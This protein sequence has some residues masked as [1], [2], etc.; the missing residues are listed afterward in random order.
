MT[1]SGTRT[2]A[3]LSGSLLACAILLSI[4]PALGQ[5]DWCAEY[6][7]DREGYEEDLRYARRTGNSEMVDF[8]E[9]M[10]KKTEIEIRRHCKQ[11]ERV[12]SRIKYGDTVP[13]SDSIPE[14]E[15]AYDVKIGNWSLKGRETKGLHIIHFASALSD[16]TLIGVPRYYGT[17]LAFHCVSDSPGPPPPGFRK[18]TE[19]SEWG[20]FHFQLP[21][22]VQ[23]LNEGA[24]VRVKVRADGTDDVLDIPT[25]I[26]V[27][28]ANLDFQ[29]ESMRE[30]FLSMVSTSERMYVTF[31]AAD[32]PLHSQIDL[33]G[34][35]EVVRTLRA[36]CGL[37]P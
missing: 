12:D 24:R 21:E 5:T 1:I 4:Q 6:K 36:F 15:D 22:A 32:G 19:T 2:N 14:S 11:T 25:T 16:L 10:L 27:A 31:P 33:A 35:A 20:S 9:H 23:G 37:E 13:R 34:G 28:A 18:G 26:D 3:I 7:L 29:D 8:Y 17:L 30:T